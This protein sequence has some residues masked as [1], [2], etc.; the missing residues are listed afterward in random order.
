MN[1]FNARRVALWIGC[2]WVIG[3]LLH[4]QAHTIIINNLSPYS[5]KAGSAFGILKMQDLNQKWLIVSFKLLNAKDP[6]HIDLWQGEENNQ[7]EIYAFINGEKLRVN[8]MP[9]NFTNAWEAVCSA[10]FFPQGGLTCLISSDPKINFNGFGRSL[11]FGVMGV[12]FAS[13]LNPDE[14]S[15]LRL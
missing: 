2:L 3:G 14:V 1:H 10:I 15:R 9:K 11:S 7:K 8:V 13:D 4:T 5:Y 12:S 6:L